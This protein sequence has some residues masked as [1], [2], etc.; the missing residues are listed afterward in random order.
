MASQ[1]IPG[2]TDIWGFYNVEADQ[3]VMVINTGGSAVQKHKP[4]PQNF[5]FNF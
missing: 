2:G 3:S 1:K 5:L 4:H